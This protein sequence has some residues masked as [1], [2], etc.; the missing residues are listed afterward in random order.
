ME[1]FNL[2]HQYQLYLKRVALTESK[3]HPDQRRE[4]R[5]A[6]M[7]ACGQMIFLLRDELALLDEDK[8]IAVLEK[9]KN[10]V[11]NFFIKQN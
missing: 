3:M 2:E 7:G 8:A 10:E 1:Q 4:T 9:M 11:G 5:Q 6:F